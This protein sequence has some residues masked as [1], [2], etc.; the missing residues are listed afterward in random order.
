MGYCTVDDV[1]SA[2]PQFAREQAGSVSDA[3][4]QGWIDDRKARIR[5]KLLARGIDPDALVL[6]TDQA[7][8]LKSLNR[9][10]AIADLGTALLSTVT[11]QPGE[12]SVA[13]GHRKAFETVLAEIGQGVHD[14]LFTADAKTADVRPQFGGTAGAE[15]DS[16][17]TPV[18]LGQNRFFGKNQ[19]F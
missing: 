17:E 14:R 12:Y 1:C 7:A 10:G 9:D 13:A 18:D 4:I 19:Q 5:S 2:F 6:D 8:F 11:L 3:Q 15:T 16:E